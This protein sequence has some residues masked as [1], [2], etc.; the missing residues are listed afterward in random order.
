MDGEGEITL[1]GYEDG[2]DVCIEVIDNGMGIPKENIALL[3]TDDTRVHK[4]GSGIGLRN[5]DQR[6]KLYFKGDYGLT[7]ES[8]LDE[9]TTVRIRLPKLCYSEAYK[10]VQDEEK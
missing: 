2:N 6:I 4:K 1:R 7:I 5:I 10:E 3:L 8:E 9:G